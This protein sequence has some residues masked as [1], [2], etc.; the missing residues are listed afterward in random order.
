MNAISRMHIH[1]V[2]VIVILFTAQGF[3][4]RIVKNFN[5]DWRFARGEQSR[6]V[7]Q[8]DF[9]DS[10]WESIDLPH[11]WAIAGPFDPDGNGSTGKLPWRGVGWYRKT[12]TL[13]EA[14]RHRRIYI[15]FD[16]VMA[17]PKIYINGQLAGEWDYGYMSFR[18]D[19]TPFVQF[20]MDNVIAVK[21]DT[22]DHRS[23]WYPGAGIYRKVT[24]TIYNP[25]HI[26][27][28]GTFITTPQ[29]SDALA[30]VHV[31]STVENHLD[32][33]SVATAEVTLT[34]PDGRL[35]A[36]GRMEDT[37]P[38]QGSRLFDQEF[39]IQNPQRW[40]IDS[41]RLYT[42]Q[43]AVYRDNNI[44]DTE[45][46][47]FGVRT[48][49][50][51]AD[52]GFW[53]NGRRIQ[54][55]GVN[56]HHDLGP[57]GAAFNVRAMER[58][59]EIMKE[60]G[61][62]ALR[63]SHNPPAPEVLDLCD[64]M[65]IVVWD[66]AFDKWDDTA[67][68]LDNEPLEEHGER[69]LRNLVMRDR[70]HPSVV[71]WSIGNEIGTQ[72]PGTSG[73]GKTHENVTVMRDF[74]LRYD[75]TRPVTIGND[76]TEDG[77]TD[78]L[79][80]LDVVGYNY[81]RRYEIFRETHPDIPIVYSESASALSTRGF[82]E[83]PLP[84]SKTQ[85]SSEYFQVSSYDYHAAAWSDIPDKEFYLMENDDF[86]AG[87]FVWTGFDYLGEPT[88]FT[89][90]ARSSY[91]GIVDLVG[92][93]KDRYYLY[94]SYW[95]PDVT[96]VHILPHWNWPDRIGQTVPVYVYTNGNT[97]EL[98]LNGR[99]LGVRAK[100]TEVSE[101]INLAEGKPTLASSEMSA[102][103]SGYA[104]D[105]DSNTSW[106]A[107]DDDPHQ[108]WQVDLGQI[109][110]IHNV[111]IAFDRS[112]GNPLYLILV[113]VDGTDWQ[114]VETGQ[115]PAEGFS[116]RQIIHHL[117]A[118]ARYLRIEFTGLRPRQQR[119]RSQQTPSSADTLQP[120][121]S[122]PLGLQQEQQTLQA[123]IQEVGIYSGDI[124]EAYYDVVDKYRLHW[125]DVVYEPGELKAVAYQD[126]RKIGEAIVRTAG[127]P[128]AIRLTPDRNEILATGEDLSFILVETVDDKGVLCPLADNVIH[129]EIS[130]PAEIA[131]IGN[132][133]PLSL[134]SFQSDTHQ[135]FYGKAMLILRSIEGEE[136]EVRV[137][138]QSD[139]LQRETMLLYVVE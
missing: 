46:N 63:T 51:T 60:M 10:D 67:D 25:I 92:I 43:T 128:T 77:R 97:A 125:D 105:Q 111:E 64:R 107:T 74:V 52:D 91:F 34:D 27:H 19:A 113:S 11:D 37:I 132:G 106:L 44:V 5:R 112:S 12:F 124:N 30:T 90:E 136:G 129:F 135:L 110:S 138:A 68:R 127:E 82:Y 84:E 85:Y 126:G 49:R 72:A 29:V 87:E 7:L 109:E 13:N 108:W 38:A 83:F 45:A 58:Q 8:I 121:L 21:V 69:Q 116:R 73:S 81:G 40:D 48:F 9:D 56:L 122:Q 95:R 36:I 123:G 3:A 104:N 71:L 114:T 1:V 96:T 50:F 32:V 101:L 47:T 133:N 62:N 23:R 94:K 70:N 22:R 79:D 120:S 66:E 65:G 61:V 16:G 86:V 42:V 137:A 39:E 41:P 78:V 76:N 59:L 119:L 53:L 88:P 28:W 134:E 80:A 31:N 4:Q 17:F 118:Q 20:G 98:F 102:N 130:G 89:Q 6:E 35:V 24:L 75:P 15:D 54:L 26:A 99:S 100:A 103:G 139:G 93:P 57:L 18:I 131:G 55:H 2:V 14:D 117:D 115:E 33:V